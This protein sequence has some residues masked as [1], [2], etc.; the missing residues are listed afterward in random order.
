M[1]APKD[2]Y[3]VLGV[4]ESAPAEEIKK[5]YRRL[6]KKYHPDV[7]GGDKAK[8]ARFKEIS[9]AYEVV[10]EE[11]KRTQYDAERRNPFAGMG[12]GGGRPG[13][14]AG[15]DLSDLF[16]RVGREG[17]GFGDIFSEFF[18]GRTGRGATAKGIDMVARIDIDLP[19]AAL[20]GEHTITVEGKRY[21]V[22]IPAGVEE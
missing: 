16:N 5:A 14:G 18:G 17:G 21:T 12:G 2:Y 15:P 13:A 20:G 7:T 9:E 3:R 11:K 6:A 4:A 22:K 10:G 8:E 1:P 19:R